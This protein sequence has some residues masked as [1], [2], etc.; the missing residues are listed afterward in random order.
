MAG[1]GEGDCR[2][3]ASHHGRRLRVGAWVKRTIGR[4]PR[5]HELYTPAGTP[6]IVVVPLVATG[7]LVPLSSTTV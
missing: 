6:P 2:R 4:E 7:W 5:E 3:L 1:H